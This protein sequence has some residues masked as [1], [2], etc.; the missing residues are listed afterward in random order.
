MRDRSERLGS[1]LTL[2]S[3]LTLLFVVL[4]LTHVIDWNWIWI[5]SPL[6]ITAGIGLIFVILL[7]A[8]ESGIKKKK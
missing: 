1:G 5:L 4:K 2:P 6:W 3:T 8:V 7:V